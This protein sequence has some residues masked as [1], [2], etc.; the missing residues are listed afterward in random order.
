MMSFQAEQFGL[1]SGH[2]DRI[3]VS[4]GVADTGDWKREGTELSRVSRAGAG[5][6]SRRSRPPN[7]LLEPRGRRRAARC[8][9]RP[10]RSTGEASICSGDGSRD[11]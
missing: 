2:F 8:D 9:G 1:S 10:R 11:A 4:R 6:C 5:W 7:L 3:F